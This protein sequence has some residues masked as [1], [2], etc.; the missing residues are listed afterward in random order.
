MD[1]KTDAELVEMVR[2]HGDTSAYEELVKRYQGHA[3]GLSY[4]ILGDWAEAQDMAQEA[5]IRAYVKLHTLDKPVKFA[6]WFQRIVFST[7]MMW[8]RSFRP[9]LYRSMGES[10]DI[11]E[12]DALPDS[13]TPTP[14]DFT[15]KNEMSKV[16][17]AAIDDLPPKYRIP[18]TMFHLDGLSYKRV[19]E[20]LDVP[21]G[22]VKSLIN[23][24]RK[25]LR[26]A[27]EGYAQGV[28]PMVKDV[29]NEHKLTEEFAQNTMKKIEGINAMKAMATNEETPNTT[30]AAFSL[31]LQAAGEN[32]TYEYL[33]GVSGSAFRFQ[34]ADDWCET[35]TISACGYNTESNALNA[36]P[37]EVAFYDAQEDDA[38]GVKEIRRAVVDSIN[39]G[40][41][42]IYRIE[43]DGLII[44]YDNGGE[45]F[46]C[47]HPQERL[48]PRG[49]FVEKRWPWC[50]FVLGKKKVSKQ[51]LQQYDQQALQLAVD[52]FRK[53]KEEGM[54]LCGELAWMTWIDELQNDSLFKRGAKWLK[55][56][57]LYISLLSARKCAAIYLK[58]I[59]DKFPDTVSDGLLRAAEMYETM[60]T[61]ILVPPSPE[62]A[63]CPLKT[64][65]AYAPEW[66]RECR[67]RQADILKRALDLERK[68][69][70]EIEK[71]LSLLS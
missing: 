44:G 33:M 2:E 68:A 30:M 11:D 57:W 7:C 47:V 29:I 31:A 4:S 5:F 15:V 48:T 55:N 66:P 51:N 46:F 52:L 59:A 18:L 19:A 35:S 13:E 34:L 16:V 20:F 71:A 62:V 61:E 38:E 28:F 54:P 22:T 10:D 3:Y 37:Y 40:I 17:L 41:P 23:R 26:T 21:I 6:A 25:K 42:V 63:P 32:L 8:L 27:L 45:A 56:W 12:F 69:I 70:G 39:R 60:T 24:A 58:T 64:S 43:E 36:I 67:H 1:Q 9:E 65:R 14:M 49:I 50:I 53:N